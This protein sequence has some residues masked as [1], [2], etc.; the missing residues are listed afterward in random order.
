MN[1]TSSWYDRH[2]LPTLLDLACGLPVITRVREQ[3]VPKATGRVLEI[4]IG[5]GLNLGHYDPHR[6]QALVG[7]DPAA[8]MHPRAQRRLR[9]LALPVELRAL[10]A[11]R[12][13]LDDGSF[14][15]V[16][17]TYTLC[18]VQDPAAALAEM[19]RVL[20]P[21]GRLLIAEHG[22]APDASVAR[23][24]ARIEPAWS[25][26]A[27]GCHLTRDVPALLRRAGFDASLAS[28][29]VTRPKVLAWTVW[30]TAVA[31]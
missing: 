10:Q 22:L 17:C 13:P 7:V 30:G 27:G 4:G 8:Q 1:P 19:R 25:R 11:E 31:R 18:S 12:L 29:Y 21:G 9:G 20:R 24:Q 26:I 5:T 6:V 3:V 14:D 2:I 16:V 28:G 15:T 23:W